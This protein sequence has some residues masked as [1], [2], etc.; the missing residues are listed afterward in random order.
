MPRYSSERS[1][2]NKNLPQ[3][4]LSS[5]KVSIFAKMKS[6]ERTIN[7]STQVSLSSYNLQIPTD[8]LSILRSLSKRLGWKI[9]KEKVTTKSAYEKSL[10]DVKN[11]NV[12][13]WSSPQDYFDKMGIWWLTNLKPQSSLTKMSNDASSV[14]F[15]WKTF[16]K[17]SMILLMTVK[18]TLN[19]SLIAC[20]ATDVVSGNVIFIPTGYL[21]GFR[22]MKNWLSWCSIPEPI[23]TCFKDA[24][25]RSFE[26]KEHIFYTI[27]QQRE[28]S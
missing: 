14:D 11:G 21:F 9:K 13:E 5:L 17:S 8:D 22:M 4:L 16:K 18:L 23:V 10:E 1:S 15:L 25:K 19:T 27:K 28:P 24:I 2:A 20:L 7:M 26:T 12:T 3:N 6:R